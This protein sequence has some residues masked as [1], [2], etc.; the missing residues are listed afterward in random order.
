MPR[1]LDETWRLLDDF[2]EVAKLLQT[3]GSPDEH[4]LSTVCETAAKAVG[5]DHASITTVRRGRFTTAAATSDVPARV[6]AF[7][8]ETKEGPCQYTVRES[9][10]LRSDDLARETRWPTFGPKVAADLGVHSLLTHVL[11]V[12]ADTLASLTVYAAEPHAF[13]AE[14]E[15]LVA[16]FGTTATA[17]VRAA[18]HQD[19]V[20]NLE[21][22]LRTSRH[23][24]VALGILM[25]VNRVNLDDAWEIM[26]KASQNRNIKVSVLAEQVIETGTPAEL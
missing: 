2:V 15:T 1:A 16:I 4:V 14:H 10:I 13:T 3:H 24:G 8:S 22:A 21:K 20:E 23:I 12:G 25:T 7:Q 5:A 17:T 26:V 19:E 6:D 9:P 11:P 18:L